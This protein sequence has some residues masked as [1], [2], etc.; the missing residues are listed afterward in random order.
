MSPYFF[1][2]T[3]TE[4]LSTRRKLD[5]LLL[6]LRELK[7]IDRGIESEAWNYMVTHY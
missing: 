5:F 1:K 7:V 4:S 2:Y 3:F 6:T